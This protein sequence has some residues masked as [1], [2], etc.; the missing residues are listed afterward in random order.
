MRDVSKERAA[1]EAAIG[2]VTLVDVLNRNAQRFA[3]LPA[4]NWSDDAGHHTISWVAYREK[5]REVAAGL[6]SLGV[7]KGDF[8]AIMSGNRPEHVIS[9]LGTVFAGGVPVSLYNTLA[10]PQI[11]YVANHCEAKVAI[12]ENLEYMKRWEAA[13]PDLAALEWVVLMEGAENYATVDWVVSWDDL[14]SRGR[15]ALAD[16]PT[17]V[18]RS[19]E[20]VTQDDL[21]TLIY[22]S[23]TTGT[24]RA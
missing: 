11:Q 21:A 23:G 12:V 14:V 17:L 16:D 20:M 18:D 15:T 2:D 22:T 9:D 19:S 13:K 24:P 6:M 5:V 1:I 3:S 7:D 8:V 4:I 10:T